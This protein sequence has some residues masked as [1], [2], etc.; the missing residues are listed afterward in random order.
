MSQLSPAACPEPPVSTAEYASTVCSC[1]VLTGVRGEALGYVI[2]SVIHYPVHFEDTEQALSPHLDNFPC[3][4]CA[5]YLQT[6]CVSLCLQLTDGGKSIY[7]K[8]CQEWGTYAIKNVP[9]VCSVL[10]M[11]NSMSVFSSK[12]IFMA[13]P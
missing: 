12:L 3:S 13:E 4:F 1:A 7:Y 9:C 5:L 8:F 10:G 6:V 11:S 2:C